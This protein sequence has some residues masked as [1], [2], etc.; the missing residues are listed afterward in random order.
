MKKIVQDRV[1]KSLFYYYTNG[2][3][4]CSFFPA[5]LRRLNNLSQILLNVSIDSIVAIGMMILL[6][7]GNFDLSVGR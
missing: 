7:S 6:I 2:V 1:F 4:S 5:H 3:S